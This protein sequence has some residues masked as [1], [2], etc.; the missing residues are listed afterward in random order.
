[1]EIMPQTL[2]YGILNAHTLHFLRDVI[3]EASVD[4]GGDLSTSKKKGICSVCPTDRTWQALSWALASS[5]A[6]D[7]PTLWERIKE[8]T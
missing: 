2:E 8:R 5:R 3:C 4:R 6:A 7:V 1:M